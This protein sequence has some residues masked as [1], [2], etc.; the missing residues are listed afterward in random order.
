[1]SIL[2]PTVVRPH[3][4]GSLHFLGTEVSG[5]SGGMA[6]LNSGGSRLHRSIG[7]TLEARNQR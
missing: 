4:A 5:G 3:L 6:V 1:M 2:R 7:V